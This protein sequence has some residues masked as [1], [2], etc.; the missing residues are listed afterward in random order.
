VSTHAL[1]GRYTDDG[2]WRAVWV[3]MGG[4]PED[5]GARLVRAVELHGGDPGPVVDHVAS[6][7]GWSAW[8]ALPHHPDDPDDV[9]FTPEN[10]IDDVHWRYLFDVDARRLDVLPG[11]RGATP[12][13]Q[14]HFVD[15]RA[16]VRLGDVELEL[17]QLASTAEAWRR[18]C[19]APIAAAV[20]GVLD[21]LGV[22]RGGAAVGVGERA[23]PE[24]PMREL[25]LG[26]RVLHLPARGAGGAKELFVGDRVVGLPA[27]E[28]WFEARLPRWEALC[29]ALGMDLEVV[30]SGELFR[31]RKVVDVVGDARREMTV[32]E[33]ETLGVDFSVG[34][35][36]GQVVARAHMV[37]RWL[38]DEAWTQSEGSDRS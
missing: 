26:G 19:P 4:A 24:S 15:G 21:D 17:G 30:D 20:D 18:R 38:F 31:F 1:V 9:T 10:V 14:V 28:D 34:D 29:R 5:L 6:T 3:H 11:A 13:W 12:A 37:W 33:A 7:G 32:A 8:P 36:L 25:R 22:P 2:G 16:D 27:A 23:R 35:E